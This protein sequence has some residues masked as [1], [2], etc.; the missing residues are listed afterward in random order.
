[1]EGWVDERVGMR[2]E[3][4]DELNDTVVSVCLA[5]VKLCRF[6]YAVLYSTTILL[7]HWFAILAELGLL[8]RIM[9]RD[10]S[11]RWN[12]TYDMLIFV[13]EY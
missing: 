9:P 7:L 3:E 4:L 10:V 5:I 1:M 13:L 2:A 8:A 11:T 6:S 12:S